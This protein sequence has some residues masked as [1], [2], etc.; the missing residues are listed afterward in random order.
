MS[1]KNPKTLGQLFIKIQ[2]QFSKISLY[3]IQNEII[4]LGTKT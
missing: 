2:K 3:I 1:L 4:F